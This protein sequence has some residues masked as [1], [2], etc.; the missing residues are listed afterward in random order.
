[1]SDDIIDDDFKEVEQSLR[2][3]HR[4]RIQ[5]IAGILIT[6]LLVGGIA[7]YQFYQS[8]QQ[9]VIAQLQKELQFAALALGARLNEYKSIALQVTSRTQARI[10]LQNYNRGEITLEKFRSMPRPKLIDAI[11][12]SPEIAGVRRYDDQ[13]SP[14]KEICDSMESS[15]LEQLRRYTGLLFILRPG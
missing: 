8:R 14:Q 15:W 3:Q 13:H 11:R 10:L 7:S 1:M 9:S 2:L 12:L 4:L 6:S 5:A